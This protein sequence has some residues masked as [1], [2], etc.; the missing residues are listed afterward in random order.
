[1]IVRGSVPLPSRHATSSCAGRSYLDSS[2]FSRAG[3]LDQLEYEGF[4]SEQA[5]YG[6]DQAYGS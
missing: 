2:A 6:V 3:L 1:M 4:T 5:Q